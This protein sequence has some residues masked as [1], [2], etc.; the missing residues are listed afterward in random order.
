MYTKHANMTT[1]H[2]YNTPIR[3]PFEVLV[4]EAIH[5]AQYVLNVCV[6]TGT[7]K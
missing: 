3:I 7:E 1:S 6:V 2:K 4:T 5:M